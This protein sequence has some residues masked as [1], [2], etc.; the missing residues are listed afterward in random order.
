MW[1]RRVRAVWVARIE[2]LDTWILASFDTCVWGWNMVQKWCSVS[3]TGNLMDEWLWKEWRIQDLPKFWRWEVC[4]DSFDGHNRVQ[5]YL[6]Q[7]YLSAGSHRVPSPTHVS[8]SQHGGQVST[9]EPQVTTEIWLTIIGVGSCLFHTISRDTSAKPHL[10]KILLSFRHPCCSWDLGLGTLCGVI[11][12]QLPRSRRLRLHGLTSSDLGLGTRV[13]L[14][15][16]TH[17]C[18]SIRPDAN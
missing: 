16:C 18:T 12:T 17:F 9:C 6:Q 4:W 7:L 10:Q 8:K 11:S 2:E 13:N 5:H 14:T 15:M 1:L 3:H